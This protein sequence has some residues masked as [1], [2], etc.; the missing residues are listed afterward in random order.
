MVRLRVWRTT[1]KVDVFVVA[2]DV[3]RWSVVV[4]ADMD[5][6]IGA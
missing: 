3:Y 5:V 4:V 6:V 1:V 2:R